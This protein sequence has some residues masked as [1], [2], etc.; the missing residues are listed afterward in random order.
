MMMPAAEITGS[1]FDEIFVD[2]AVL[3]ILI[4]F[5]TWLRLR[6]RV[7]RQYHIPASLIAGVMGL[8]LGPYFA[9]LIP[10][11]MM[12]CWSAMSGRLIVLVFAPMMMG[13]HARHKGLVK[14]TM[15]EVIVCYGLTCVQYAVPLLLGVFLLTPVFGVDPLFGT[16]VEQ[17]WAG[18]HGTAGGM[19]LVFE[20]LGWTDGAS[21][22]ITSATVGLVYGIV[23]GVVLINVAVR[24][25]WTTQIKDTAM[26]QEDGEELY[27]RHDQRPVSGYDTIASGVVNNYA[28]HLGLISVAVFVGWI[29]NQALKTYLH[30]SVSWYVTA[31]FGG[32]ILQKVLD[33]T[34]WGDVVDAGTMN[35]IQGVA[36]EF[37]V[38]GA[39]ATVNVT[40]IVEYA[41][42]LVIQQ[43][44]MMVIMVF[45]IIWYVRH[46]MGEYW[47]EN[48]MV[49]FG[50]YTGV[51]AT[52]LLL[53][54]TC[55]P[56][57]RTDAAE[58]FA[59]RAPFCTWALGGGVLTSM[60]PVWVSRYGALQV[61]LVY[62]AG[63]LVCLVIPRLI[64]SWY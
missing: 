1:I 24:K 23:G 4:L 18:G 26:L 32:L 43:G 59:A 17:G 47:F 45:A 44:I 56:E 55:D 54:K 37:L 61:G 29:L 52:G 36:L 2:V 14:R 27:V 15:A 8:L 38:A 57:M 33:R 51:A 13:R 40:V 20:G 22:S 64:K 28:F 50:T 63:V 53:L 10:Q 46:V 39:V 7:L 19:A 31:L 41:I 11:D 35:N 6:I 42:P 21:L 9:G 25:G 3:G 34:A 62:L 60:T 30:F 5:A 58:V 16:I 48:G 49:L 12:D